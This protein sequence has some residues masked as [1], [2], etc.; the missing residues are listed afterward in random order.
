MGPLPS[1]LLES[2]VS[3]ELLLP[4]HFLSFSLFFF[5]FHFFLPPFP[6]NSISNFE[7]LNF[8]KQFWHK[9]QVMATSYLSSTSKMEMNS[10]SFLLGVL[11]ELSSPLFVSESGVA[12]LFLA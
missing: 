2:L 10:E 9:I 7:K 1:S 6:A 3:P 12:V 8:S 11:P 4:L 5:Q